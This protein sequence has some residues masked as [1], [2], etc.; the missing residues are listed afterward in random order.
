VQHSIFLYCWQ[1]HVAHQHT[2]RIVEFTLQQWLR[3]RATV[4]PFT[5]ITYL[6]PL[7][8]KRKVGFQCCHSSLRQQAASV[9][10][11]C[12]QTRILRVINIEFIML[13]VEKLCKERISWVN[14]S[15]SCKAEMLRDEGNYGVSNVSLRSRHSLSL[16]EEF[17][18]PR[19]SPR[20]HSVVLHMC[21]ISFIPT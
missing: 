19:N 17:W 10:T 8:V 2:K 1:W 13:S 12:A 5:C 15:S 14:C 9:D 4:L 11:L 6:A 16:V 21:I 20:I 18:K 3:D 7:L